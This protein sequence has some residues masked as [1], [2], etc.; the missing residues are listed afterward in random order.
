M[1]L[2]ARSVHDDTY[3]DQRDGA[4]RKVKYIRTY[5]VNNAPP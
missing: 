4:A 5:A 1:L 3:A 2:T